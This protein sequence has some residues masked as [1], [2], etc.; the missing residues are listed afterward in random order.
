MILQ[1]LCSYYERLRAQPD[2]GIAPPGY[3]SEKISYALVLDRDGSLVAIRDIRETSGK[4]PRPTELV[5]P[6]PPKR[7]SGIKPCFLWDK[8][9]Y[10]LGASASRS[11]SA[12]RVRAMVRASR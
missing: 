7:T 8:T 1:A 4:K 11:L 5:V 10:V 2:S 3:S 9:S 6:D 12:E